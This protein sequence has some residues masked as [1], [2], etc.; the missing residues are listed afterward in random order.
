MENFDNIEAAEPADTS[1][2]IS[3]ADKVSELIILPL[4]QIKFLAFVAL[5]LYV[6][7][8]NYMISEADRIWFGCN[9]SFYMALVLS[10]K[11]QL[12]FLY[13]TSMAIHISY[14]I[15]DS[16]SFVDMEVGELYLIMLYGATVV[17]IGKNTGREIATFLMGVVTV[18]GTNIMISKYGSESDSFKVAVIMNMISAWSKNIY[19]HKYVS[20]F[21]EEMAKEESSRDDWSDVTKKLKDSTRKS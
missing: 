12:I 5:S 18:N 8:T 21:L 4:E 10:Q 13:T 20:K 1:N 15:V 11:L 7:I 9:F 16:N 2:K 19:M 6:I 3:K 17:T 14:M